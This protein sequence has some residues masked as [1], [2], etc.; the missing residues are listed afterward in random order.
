MTPLAELGSALADRY[1]LERELGAGGMATV[2]LAE[3]LKHRRKVA[4]KVL[5]PDLAAA[6]GPE[7][8]LREITIA[9]NLQHP[10]ILPLHDSGE[11]DGFLYYVMPFVDGISLR[12][13]LTRDGELPIPD[14]VRILRDLADAMAHA[15]SQG[16]VH[17][18]I[19][20]ENIMLS[21]RHALVT[22]FGVAKAVTEATGRHSLTTAGVALGTPA[23]MAPEQAAADP[24]V[25]HRADIYA[26]GVVAYELLTGQPPFTAP[27]PQALLSAQVTM[28]PQPVTAHRPSI[29]PALA[30]LV[31]K[32]LEKKPA[33]RYQSADELIPQLEAVLTPSGGTTPTA[34]RAVPRVSNRL[35]AGGVVVLAVLLGL[36]Y[37]RFGRAA[38]GDGGAGAEARTVAVLA[39]PTAEDSTQWFADGIVQT[40]EGKLLAVPGLEIHS[41]TSL[42]ATKARELPPEEIGRRLH[43][44]NLLSVTVA[45]NGG[46][47][48]V[49]AQLLRTSDGRVEWASAPIV[50]PVGEIF[51]VQDSLAVRTVAALR[52]PLAAPGAARLVARG[53]SVV[54][55]NEA[56]MRGE[57]YRRRFKPAQA[58]PFLERAAALDPRFAQAHASLAMS[59]TILP[60]VDMG[61]RDSSLRLGRQSADRALALD[62]T[63]V[64]AHV[65]GGM[66]SLLDYRFADAERE[67]GRWATQ[68][69]SDAEGHLWHAFSLFF[70]GPLPEVQEEIRTALRIDPERPDGHVYKQQDLM[71][72]GRFDEAL[73]ATRAQLADPMSTPRYFL[74]NLIQIYAFSG[75]ADSAVAVARRILATAPVDS[76][77]GAERFAILFAFASAGQWRAADSQRVLVLRQPTNSPHFTETI[78][79]LVDGDVEAA[80]RAMEAGVEAREPGFIIAPL[81]CEP[82]FDRLKTNARY[83]ALLKR[84]GLTPCPPLPRWP[85]PPRPR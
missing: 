3:D 25:D 2:Y 61:G 47:L 72:T 24:H 78:V 73:A 18:D 10:H 63:L 70:L 22:D 48:R 32:C 45:R 8:F 37:W 62:S 77:L 53:T 36:G 12:D 56:Y 67:L 5:R 13:K 60:L 42:A 28:T 79:A 71:M 11:A 84:F 44:A 29:P 51:A 54:E 43:V 30:G 26:F 6:L 33:D 21:G 52:I 75:Q 34:T 66:Q 74:T 59:Y 4:V 49:S 80:A 20:P 85:I 81:T 35:L 64:L 39:T 40:L 38:G 9:V 76:D 27:T 7:R 68:N 69:P 16:V 14:A 46:T 15:H 31:M 41:S 55:A 1:R 17:R 19:K 57:W 65:A 23:Y 50:A 82:V 58:I 83:L